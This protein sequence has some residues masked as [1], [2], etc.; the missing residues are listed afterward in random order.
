MVLDSSK[1]QF[2]ADRAAVW[3]RLLK[4]ETTWKSSRISG[5]QVQLVK[6]G[7]DPRIEK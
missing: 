2:E 6:L 7:F 5:S 3:E 4:T 1:Y